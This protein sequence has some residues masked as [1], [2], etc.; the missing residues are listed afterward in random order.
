MKRIIRNSVLLLVL[1][2]AALIA[3]PDLPPK[4]HVPAGFVTSGAYFV[5][6]D[7]A[8]FEYP[9]AGK[10]E[11]VTVEG[12]VWSVFLGSDARPVADPA[13]TAP[14][15]AAALE[16]DGWTILRHDVVLVAKSGDL[17]L[18]GYGNSGSFKVTLA[19]Q[20]PLPRPITLT[21]PNVAVENTPDNGDFPWLAPF[22]GA[23]L[24]S[25]QHGDRPID[26]SVPHAKETSFSGLTVTKY[27]DVPGDVSSYEFVNAY[28]RALLAAG[29]TVVR[30][31]IGGDGFV[32]AHYTKNGRDI[33]LYTHFAGTGQMV[34]AADTGAETAAAN[35]KQA[36][37]T[38]GHVAVYGI[39]FDSD[40]ATP[41][42][43]SAPTLQHILDL[44]TSTPVLRLDI[45]GHTDDSGMP[46]HNQQ[47]SEQRASSVR[48]WL[49]SHGIAASRLE[50]HGYGATRPVA[51]NKTPEGKARNRR[52]EL[53]KR[54]QV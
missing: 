41:T 26:I 25:T 8:R 54:G 47:L 20:A 1:C 19:Q 48:S 32:L 24:K 35:L 50:S 7:T 37:D 2:P 38:A 44:L 27:Y 40:S 52:V 11:R 36:L 4:F 31:A 49:V 13:V 43:E 16:H 53:A 18:T 17:W 14:K 9:L 15:I 51:D 10:T 34:R 21:P 22:P 29:W 5:Q 28:R 6:F 23:K 42:A 46:P 12:R 33:W 39:Y 30:D 45:E 3:S